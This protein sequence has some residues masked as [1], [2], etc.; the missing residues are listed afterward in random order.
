MW[1]FHPLYFQKFFHKL[2][3]SARPKGEP[4]F[5]KARSLSCRRFVC[6]LGGGEVRLAGW[7]GG[8][9]VCLWPPVQAPIQRQTADVESR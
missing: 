8:F 4:V 3:H 2:A 5:S 9:M 6:T 1:F 7:W